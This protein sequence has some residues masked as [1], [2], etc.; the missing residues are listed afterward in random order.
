MREGHLIVY[1]AG[2]MSG[3]EHYNIPAFI[4]TAEAIRGQGHIVFCPTELG[5]RDLRTWEAYVAR[6]TEKLV[7]CDAVAVLPGWEESRGALLE[8][9]AARVYDKPVVDAGMLAC[10]RVKDLGPS[11]ENV[12]ALIAKAFGKAEHEPVCP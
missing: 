10:S 11:M 2:P 12:L 4:E 9:F 3:I 8:V 7:A 6:D 5:T 1:L